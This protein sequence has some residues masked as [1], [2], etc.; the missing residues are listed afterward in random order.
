MWRMCVG[1]ADAKDLPDHWPLARTIPDPRPTKCSKLTYP[2]RLPKTAV[3]ICF[4]NETALML[5]MESFERVRFG[6]ALQSFRLRSI[7]L[8]ASAPIV[9]ARIK[10]SVFLFWISRIFGMAS[11]DA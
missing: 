6:L 4:R 11:K 5:V 7:I 9:R 1:A 3:V 8:S 10:P 2:A